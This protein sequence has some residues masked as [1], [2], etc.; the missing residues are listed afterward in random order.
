M[1][2]WSTVVA[3]RDIA[4]AAAIGVTMR[5]ELEP[6]R[7]GEL[8]SRFHVAHV[9]TGHRPEERQARDAARG[10][11]RLP[12]VLDIRETF[13][14]P[15]LRRRESLESCR[16]ERLAPNAD[17]SDRA[18]RGQGERIQCKRRR[19]VPEHRDRDERD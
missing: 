9:G 13:E 6:L 5:K 19:R 7:R 18:E 15:V 8:A 14:I 10:G 3:G 1:P 17:H 11:E 12:I 16:I 4:R 2:V